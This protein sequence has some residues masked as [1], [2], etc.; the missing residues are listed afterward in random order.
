MKKERNM[1]NVPTSMKKLL[2]KLRE[3][4]PES[5]RERFVEIISEEIG[6][7]EMENTL[8]YALI[9][10]AIGAIFEILPLDSITGIDDWV[11]IGAALGA[12]AGFALDWKARE[13]RQQ[14]KDLILRALKEAM[15][16]EDEAL[17]NA[18]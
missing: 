2:L 12:W 8:K 9:G 3:R 6:K 15:E 13:E 7:L 18:A 11:E 17:Q 14:T 1:K 16:V 10:A 4:L 5:C